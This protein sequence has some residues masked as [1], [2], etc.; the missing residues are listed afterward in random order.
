MPEEAQRGIVN[1]TGKWQRYVIVSKPAKNFFCR[2]AIKVIGA[3]LPV[4]YAALDIFLCSSTRLLELDSMLACAT[5][6]SFRIELTT[7]LERYPV[8]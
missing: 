4:K 3:T 1:S 7:A 5:R 2:V 8:F 6:M